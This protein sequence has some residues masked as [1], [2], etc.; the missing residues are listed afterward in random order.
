MNKMI[1]PLL[2][3]AYIFRAIG[4]DAIP[5]ELIGEWAPDDAVFQN[6]GVASGYAIY[7]NT[8][9][10]AAT[11]MGPEFIDIKWHAI[12][13]ATNH[14]LTLRDDPH[15]W[16]QNTSTN[17]LT[18]DPKTKTL[19]QFHPNEVLRRHRDFVPKSVIQ[20]SQ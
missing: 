14:V 17:N 9:G 2:F 7:I 18:Y 19:H 8:N 5:S 15:P 11:V 1:L 10:M 6:G 20:A 12:Y 3:G 4:A 13:D 16:L